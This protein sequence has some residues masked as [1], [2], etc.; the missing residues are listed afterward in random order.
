MSPRKIAALLARR[1]SERV[2]V[3]YTR[4][5]DGSV[6]TRWQVLRERFLAPARRGF[7]WGLA[8]LVPIAF[9]ACATQSKGPARGQ[10]TGRVGPRSEAQRKA[11]EEERVIVTGGI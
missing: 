6:V 5:A 2:C 9:G 8:A 3:T 4:A 7:A 10:L 11:A 1:E